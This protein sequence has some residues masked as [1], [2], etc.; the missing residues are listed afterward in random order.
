ME[1]TKEQRHAIYIKALELYGSTTKSEYQYYGLC[2]YIEKASKLLFN[3]YNDS[4]T[5]DEF[6]LKE[7]KN[8]D[9][10]DYSLMWFPNTKYYNNKRR[11]ILK[12]LIKETNETI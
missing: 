7:P 4:Y 8:Y 9:K 6:V 1:L 2:Y 11:E 3:C 12:E 10:R 5:F